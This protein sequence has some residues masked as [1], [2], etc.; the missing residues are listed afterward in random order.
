M[1]HSQPSLPRR[2]FL[3]GRFL[4]SLKTEQEKMQ[5]YQAIRPPWVNLDEFVEKCTACDKCI[6]AC[7]TQI[8]I[9]GKGGFPEIDFARG[10]CTFCQHCMES[11]P[12][13]VFRATDETP[14]LHKVEIQ[15]NC[16]LTHNIECRSCGDSCDSRAIRFRPKLGG[17]VE[18]ILALESCNGCGACLAVCPTQA[19]HILNIA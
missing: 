19:I 13:D 17:I 6:T 9:K 7:E 16:L 2:A 3:Q 14:W 1:Q 12:E 18:L 5:G 15:H 8:I 10:E 4:H 11:C